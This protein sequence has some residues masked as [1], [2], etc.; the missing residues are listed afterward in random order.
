MTTERETEGSFKVRVDAKFAVVC[1]VVYVAVQLKVRQPHE[2]RRHALAF[3]E[4]LI[5]IAGQLD[6]D[7]VECFLDARFSSFC[8]CKLYCKH[9]TFKG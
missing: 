4:F 9:T 3:S 5:E 8:K 2:N 1:I 6:S 7:S